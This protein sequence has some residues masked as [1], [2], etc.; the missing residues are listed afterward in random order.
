MATTHVSIPK[1]FSGGDAREWFQK[2]EICSD[3]NGWDATK[4]A[5]KLL[6]LLEGEALAAW[7]ELTDEE[8]K[9]YSV[10]KDKL[11]KKMAPLEF[12][13]LEEFQKRSIFLGESVGMYL[14]E[15]KRLLQQA[16]PELTADAR[17]QLLIHQ[18]LTGLPASLS[19][20][21]R[22]SGNTAD[23]DELVQRAKILMVV[24]GGERQTAAVHSGI[25]EVSELKSQIQELTAQVEA[26]KV[27]QKSD[28]NPPQCYYCKQPGHVQRYCPNRVRE[29][30]CY[31][32]GRPG[33]IAANCWLS[34][35][36][37]GM[38]LGSNRHP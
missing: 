15:L 4:K 14:Y 25:S 38:S 37:K 13:S 36:E 19:R 8:K 2:F 32:C 20:Q 26:L 29:R 1:S 17:K 10:A 7:M 5:K 30:R 12:V 3:A 31:I 24:D 22:A 33:H 18:F 28:R 34:G 23:L 9:D 16:M 11:I 27:A 6:T 35:N 21:L